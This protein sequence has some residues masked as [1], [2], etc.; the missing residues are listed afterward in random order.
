[1]GKKIRG[2]G[3]VVASITK[4]VGIQPCEAC[5]R[6]RE[7]WNKI[8]PNRLRKKIRELTE[9]ELASWQE[10]QKVRTLRLSSEQRLF[11]CRIFAD[12]FQVPYY[13]VC[14]SCD[15][16]PLIRMIERMDDIVKTYE[17]GE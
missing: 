10:F 17:D 11:V 6:R 2:A 14:A 3:D 16:S 13:E 5:E 7:Q 9:V 1:M 15:A 4:F 12:V 8:F